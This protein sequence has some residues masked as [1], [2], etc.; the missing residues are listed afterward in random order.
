MKWDSTFD[1]YVIKEYGNWVLCIHANQFIL[2]RVYIWAKREDCLDFA[3]ITEEERSELFEIM[4]ETKGALTKLF[5]PDLFNWAALGNAT[6]HMHLH[7]IPRYKTPR[8]FGGL[9]FRDI[10]WCKRYNTATYG[11]MPEVPEAVV[12]NIKETIQKIL[13]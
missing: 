9:E 1:K 12:Q 4:K 8:M 2:G 11:D 5:Q 3:D 10:S 13:N 7:V 6:N